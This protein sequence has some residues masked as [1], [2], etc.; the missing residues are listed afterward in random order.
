MIIDLNIDRNGWIWISNYLYYIK[1][2]Y[3][4]KFEKGYRFK[5]SKIY[6]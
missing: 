6:D 1:V 4:E 3:R 2:Y 5:K